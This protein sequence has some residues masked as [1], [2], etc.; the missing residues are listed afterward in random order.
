MEQQRISI[1]GAGWLGASLA[2]YLKD[3]GYTV[4][5]S[6]ASEERQ[7]ALQQEHPSVYQLKIQAEEVTGDWAAFSQAEVLIINITPDRSQPEKEQFAALIPLIEASPIQKV[8]FI[9]STSVYPNLN[10]VVTAA[11]GVEDQGHILYKSEQAL[12]Q[13]E[14]V[15]TTVLRLAGLIGGERHPGNFFRHS[16]RVKQGDTPVNLIHRVDCL[17]CIH[18]IIAQ[19]YWGQVLNACADSHPLKM[20]FY[21]TAAASIGAAIPLVEQNGPVAY[22]IISNQKMKEELGIQLQEPDLM[23]LLEQWY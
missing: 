7:Q 10:R 13:I 12:Q 22:K 9:S 2:T 4:Q 11:E 1:L 3:K 23:A 5:L 15:A 19:D 14:G 20:D 16:G 17:Q 6:T 8:L 21:P 18:Q